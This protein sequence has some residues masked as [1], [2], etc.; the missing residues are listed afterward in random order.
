M[1]RT[2]GF[3]DQILSFLTYA[4]GSFELSLNCLSGVFLVRVAENIEQSPIGVPEK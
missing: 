4:S 3:G 1:G 2:R